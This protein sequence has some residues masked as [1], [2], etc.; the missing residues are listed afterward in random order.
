[1][2]KREFK[3]VG[4]ERTREAL[5]KVQDQ[6][7]REGRGTVYGNESGYK[8]KAKKAKDVYELG[9]LETPER[10]KQSPLINYG[11]KGEGHKAQEELT[12]EYAHTHRL[13]NYEK[14]SENLKTRF[15]KVRLTRDGQLGVE[16]KIHDIR[17]NI[18]TDP[19][20]ALKEITPYIAEGKNLGESYVYK[21]ISSGILPQKDITDRLATPALIVLSITSLSILSSNITGNVIA[22]TTSQA[23]KL[24]LAF[25]LLG[26]VGL[27]VFKGYKRN[28][29]MK[30]IRRIWEKDIMQKTKE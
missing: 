25:C 19:E 15:D 11:R 6:A 2:V 27:A 17:K 8:V 20:A 16:G 1:M 21:Q 28:K 3:E 22:E 14:L 23:S 30:E 12:P 13:S 10:H 29:A 18:D 4:N 7:S 24:G 5:R 26:I 9:T